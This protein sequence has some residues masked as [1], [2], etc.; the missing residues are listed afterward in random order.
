M[1]GRRRQSADTTG[2][3]VLRFLLGGVAGTVAKTVTAPLDLTK[4]R[5]QVSQSPVSVRLVLEHVVTTARRSGVGALW[6]GNGAAAIRVFPYAAVQ[7]ATND[8]LTARLLRYRQDA[9]ALSGATGSAATLTALDRVVAGA[10]AGV[11]SVLATYPLDL[12]RARMAVQPSRPSPE[13]VKR[14][15][16]YSGP[17]QALL[18]IGRAEGIAGLFRG[19]PATVVGII[20]YSATSFGVFSSLK[21]SLRR[22][23]GREPTTLERMGCGALAGLLGQTAGYPLDVVRRRQQTGYFLREAE[24]VSSS[25]VND[26]HQ[27]VQLPAAGSALRAGTASPHQGMLST[28]RSIVA[29]EGWRALW[30]GVSINWF[31]GPIAVATSFAVFDALKQAAGLADGDQ[32]SRR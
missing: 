15:L 27:R 19:A 7:L 9:A 23:T 24:G 26:W 18:Q 1:A 16:A 32:A 2:Q 22:R 28:L 11:V 4:I 13:A 29:A 30:K 31:K 14:G 3:T 25:S 8:L 5:F 10:G 12:V 17:A 6:Q 21:A 20:P